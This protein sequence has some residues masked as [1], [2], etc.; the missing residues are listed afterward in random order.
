MKKGST[1]QML[2]QQKTSPRIPK[3]SFRKEKGRLARPIPSTTQK[4]KW[5]GGNNM[6]NEGGEQEV[7]GG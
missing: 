5:G 7:G 3:T 4:E 6:E 1:F 2:N